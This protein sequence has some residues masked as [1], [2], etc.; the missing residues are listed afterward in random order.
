MNLSKRSEISNWF[1]SNASGKTDYLYIPPGQSSAF[2]G[3]VANTENPTV[4]ILDFTKC[5]D[6]LMGEGWSYNEAFD[7]LHRKSKDRK[8]HE[9]IFLFGFPELH[10]NFSKNDH[11]SN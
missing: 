9:P 8:P 2:I 4:A 10:P 1:A 3:V 7:F 11:L 6:N 5:L